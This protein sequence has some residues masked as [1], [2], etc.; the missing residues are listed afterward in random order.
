IAAT[1]QLARGA[2]AVATVSRL[3]P[4]GYD[5]RVEVLGSRDHVCAGMGRHTPLHCV[6]GSSGLSDSEAAW[7]SWRTRFAQAFDR[8]M[9]AFLDAVRGKEP[10]GARPADA[11]RAQRIAEAAR[12][13]MEQAAPVLM[14]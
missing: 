5:A 3:S 13:S 8:Q 4:T 14:D 2:I 6:D 11:V 1:M 9:A 7:D 12:H 10:Q